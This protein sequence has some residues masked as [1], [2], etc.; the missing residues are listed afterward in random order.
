MGCTFFSLRFIL[1]WLAT[2]IDWLRT[3]ESWK[4][5][6]LLTLNSEFYWPGNCNIS[7]WF[8]KK[9]ELFLFVSLPQIIRSL[10]SGRGDQHFIWCWSRFP[11]QTGRP[12]DCSSEKNYKDKLLCHIHSKWVLHP[13]L[14]FIFRH[15]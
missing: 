1:S 13:F 9:T 3:W 12:N 4:K 2:Q 7:L 11:E 6:N 8:F 14:W 10:Q 5:A 15:F